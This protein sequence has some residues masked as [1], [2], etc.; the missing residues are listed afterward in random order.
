MEVVLTA[1]KRTLSLLLLRGC[2]CPLL[3]Q[4]WGVG[5]SVGMV[6]DIQ[7]KFRLDGFGK[8]DWNGW[9]S[10]QLEDRVVL[11]ATLGSLLVKGANAGLVVSIPAGAPPT[12]L[13]DLTDRINYWTVGVSYE[14][15]EGDSTSGFFGGIGGYRVNSRAVDPQ[16][17]PYRD[18]GETV[19]GW[20]AGVDT[21]FRVV[22][23]FFLIGPPDIPS[24]RF[25]IEPIAVDGQRGDRVSVLARVEN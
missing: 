5:A 2:G 7:N 13:P 14:F 9:V 17:E 15:W 4:D 18:V 23:G 11:R 25:R 1:R 10:F 12:R 22:S 8:T 6:N 16:L 24:D 19:F 20:H 3:A 21:G